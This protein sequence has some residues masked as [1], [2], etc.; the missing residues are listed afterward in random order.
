MEAIVS[1]DCVEI[2]LYPNE[3]ED[4]E[5]DDAFEAICRMFGVDSEDLESK[6]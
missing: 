2:E 4:E 3:M 6:P 5:L 1:D